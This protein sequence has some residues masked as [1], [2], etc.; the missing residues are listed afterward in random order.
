MKLSP[1]R[2]GY[3][4]LSEW[5]SLLIV[6]ITGIL[7]NGLSLLTVLFEGELASCLCG[8]LNA[9]KTFR[10]ML[11]MVILYLV[12]TLVIQ[13]ARFLKRFY[14][15][16]F[17]NSINMKMKGILYSN[18]LRKSKSFLA[19]TGEGE[20]LTAAI[21]DTDDTAEGMRKFTTEIFDTGVMII[22]YTLMLFLYDWRLTLLSLFFTPMTYFTAAL[23]KKP[24]EKRVKNYKKEASGLRSAAI[25]LSMN[26]VTY[27]I[28]GV[29]KPNRD[30][31]EENLSSY[32]K[33][34]ISSSIWVTAF[35]PL[36]KALSG[37]G[38]VFILYFGS[39]NVLKRGWTV[40]N[41]A[42]F[43][44][45]FSAFTKLTVKAAKAAKLFNSLE[46]AEVSWKRIKPML[47]TPEKLEN[48]KEEK[49]EALIVSNLSVSFGNER[50]I[51]NINIE[52]H[53]GEIIGV[54]GPVAGGKTTF[55]RVF[56]SE[57]PY[58]GSVTYGSLDITEFSERKISSL[59]GYLGHDSELFS[60]TIKNNVLCGKDDD[61]LKYLE[62]VKMKDE[63]LGMEKREDTQIGSSGE[64]LSG[65]QRKRLALAR[66]LSHPRPVLILDDPFSALDRKTE[67]EIFLNLQEYAKDRIIFLISHRL[68]NFPRVDRVLYID[69]DISYTGT[70]GELM[71]LVT[72]Y[73]NLFN[74]R[75]DGKNEKE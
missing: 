36:Y 18:L 20:L 48:I 56:L 42:E 59:F 37:L 50:I 14:V 22:S 39:M 15:R 70:H 66:T 62:M 5:R 64:R 30:K 13:A 34:A 3:Y 12:T 6:T 61:V 75:E 63:V 68:Y 33:A 44:T 27:R 52:A 32:E 11:L 8:V 25:D 46:K 31:F 53:A 49:A 4:F 73:R 55:G 41:I 16:H 38:V 23:M 60:D 45:Y 17:A 57:F 10:D 21:S 2:V 65:G 26:A 67:D 19:S 54:T 69:R 9:D 24:V 1:D 72:E 71:A 35:E 47:K 58:S 28:Y 40:W 29:E 7:Y 43:T 74:T 51:S